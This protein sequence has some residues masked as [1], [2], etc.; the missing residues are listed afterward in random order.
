MHIQEL[1][2]FEIKLHLQSKGVLYYFE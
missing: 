2:I 1:K